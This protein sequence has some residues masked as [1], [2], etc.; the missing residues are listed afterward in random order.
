VTDR[1][2]VACC[3]QHSATS[4]L[5]AESCAKSC[6]KLRESSLIHYTGSQ[7]RSANDQN[8]ND[9]LGN[10]IA[11]AVKW[12]RNETFVSK[13]GSYTEETSC[14]KLV[15]IKQ[16]IANHFLLNNTAEFLGSHGGE[17]V[18]CSFFNDTF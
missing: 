14:M 10:S 18:L 2:A 1:V 9:D 4:Q 12:G 16:C 15:S 7:V 5:R 6:A 11:W 3:L 17:D 8:A 13:I